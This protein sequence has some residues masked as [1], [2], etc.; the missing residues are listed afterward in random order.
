MPF[1][2]WYSPSPMFN[3]VQTETANVSKGKN[4]NMVDIN[5]SWPFLKFTFIK[6]N[7]TSCSAN[8]FPIHDLDP[9]PKGNDAKG[10]T[11]SWSFPLSQ[12]SGTNWLAS[13]KYLSCL[14]MKSLCIPTNVWK[15]WET[16][17]TMFR[18]YSCTY[19]SKVYIKQCHRERTLQIKSPPKKLRYK[20][21]LKCWRA[22]LKCMLVNPLNSLHF[23]TTIICHD[24]G[25]TLLNLKGFH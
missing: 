3:I 11:L 5:K 7:D 9:K 17:A 2:Y 22:P 21:Y 14:W 12:R 10:W 1:K 19:S 8:L 24:L 25:V 4:K 6:A 16:R 13:L 18:I 23:T 15:M 20:F